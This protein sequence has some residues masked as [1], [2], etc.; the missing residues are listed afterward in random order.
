MTW[1]ISF[2]RRADLRLWGLRDFAPSTAS[3]TWLVGFAQRAGLRLR[4]LLDT[5]ILSLGH[6][7]KASLE[8]TPS[9]R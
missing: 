7:P 3:M 1:F 9:L 8:D 5:R 6:S 2:A 4:D